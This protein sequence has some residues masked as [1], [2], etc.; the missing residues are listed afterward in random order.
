MQPAVL[1]V[2]SSTRRD[3][4]S[5]REVSVVFTVTY[6]LER[7][8]SSCRVGGGWGGGGGGGGRG[9]GGGGR[10]MK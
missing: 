1:A 5:V 2:V 6:F 8:C 9:E 3:V 10:G 7:V 4:F